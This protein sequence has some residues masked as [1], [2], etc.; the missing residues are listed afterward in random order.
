MFNSTTFNSI[1]FNGAG[2]NNTGF[3]D[4]PA[5]IR[6][7]TNPALATFA[8]VP[9]V[10]SV[11][12]EVVGDQNASIT[13]SDY[14]WLTPTLEAAQ[15]GPGYRPY[16]TCKVV[17]DTIVPNQILATDE[18]RNGQSATAPDG[19]IFTVGADNSNQLCL[20]KAT[21][22]SLGLGTKT[23]IRASYRHDLNASLA[24]SEY[25][26]GTYVIDIY[27]FYNL[28]GDLKAY[29]ARSIDGG[30]TFSSSVTPVDLGILNATTD[31]LYISAGKPILQANNV[32]Y[33]V[34]FYIKKETTG[35]GL[36]YYDVLFQVYKGG[37][38]FQTPQLWGGRTNPQDFIIQGI[39]NAYKD[40][41]YYLIIS[42]Y[43]TI[44]E[45]V[46]NQNYGLYSCYVENIYVSPYTQSS[47][48]Y[49]VFSTGPFWSILTEVLTSTS[50]STSN[51][52]SFT[53]PRIT[54]DGV[55]F[56]ILCKAVIVI[57]ISTATT[58]QSNA[59]TT[60]TYRYL[61]R[62]RDMKNFS[63]PTPL[64]FDDGTIFDDDK[65]YSFVAQGSYAYVLGNGFAWQYLQ[66]EIEADITNSIISYSVSEMAGSAFQLTILLANMNNQWVGPSTTKPG[67]AAIA[68]DM[69]I[70]LEQ[71][72]YNA[73]GVGETVPRN[74]FYIDDIK[75]Q[76]TSNNNVVQIVARDAIKP[77]KV[78]TTKFSYNFRGPATYSDIFGGNSLGNWNQLVGQ[79]SEAGGVLINAS[80]ATEGI[81]SLND[82]LSNRESYIMSVSVKMPELSDINGSGSSVFLLYVD[83]N[84]WLALSFT[85]ESDYHVSWSLAYMLDGAPSPNVIA[86]GTMPGT[87]SAFAGMYVPILIRQYNYMTFDI[88][89]GTPSATGNQLGA[90]DPLLYPP[91][92]PFTFPF[93][94]TPD[95]GGSID[96]NEYF[97]PG[98]TFLNST[99][100]LSNVGMEGKFAYFKYMQFGD[101]QSIQEST[102]KL[103]TLAGLNRFFTKKI[104]KDGNFFPADY[105]G[106]FTNT[107]FGMQ[108][109][110]SGFVLD[111]LH[112]IS[113]GD[114]EMKAYVL[115][116]DANADY[117]FSMVFRAQSL[118][119]TASRYKVVMKKIA[120][121]FGIAEFH[122]FKTGTGT[123]GD[124]LLI[125]SSVADYLFF[126]AGSLYSNPI[127]VDITQPHT[128]KL[129][130][131]DNYFY[132]F[133][134]GTLVL[135]WQDNNTDVTGLDFSSGYFGVETDSNST[136]VVQEISSNVMWNQVDNIA[137]NPGDDIH[138]TLKSVAGA[139]GGWVFSD[140]MGRLTSIK[141]SPADIATYSYEDLLYSQAFDNSDKEYVNQVTVFGNGVSAIYQDLAS[142]AITSKVRDLTISDFKILTYDDALT[143]A[144]FEMVNNNRFISQ[145]VPT[146]P[147]NVGS[148]IFDAINIVNTGDNSTGTD[149]DFRAYN[150]TLTNDGSKG[151]YAMEIQTG[152]L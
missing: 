53:Y 100:A 91:F 26:N 108:V 143:R 144:K 140:I 90:Y 88:L 116:T 102:D 33:G 65:S 10:I 113:D 25:I 129:V 106:S 8:E 19:T 77:L 112:T 117:S 123:S 146:N 42:A 95:G 150:Q 138:N 36:E 83:V 21:D 130:M 122:L 28:T 64:V 84:D 62:S 46:P 139:V 125:K 22:A 45:E 148:E 131:V 110:P 3:A 151:R 44:I 51:L 34:F 111:S 13:V 35:T 141:L 135:A 94:I 27:A 11:G 66:N 55:G 137:V 126:G 29:F 114:I 97:F 86:T 105:Y 99:V 30:A 89:V 124:N 61:L 49:Q 115:P 12:A 48:S 76:V 1:P 92:A 98:Q 38:N 15:L 31:N 16:Y 107:K 104:F 121:K 82:F 78:L 147:L 60:Q 152:S 69:K 74:I 20:W 39:D 133:V 68:K 128:Y 58:G 127:D 43:H 4:V 109:A 59:I 81:I 79:W 93:A 145:Q 96:V 40:G 32:I 56:D 85:K 57:G 7:N 2:A 18:V 63:Y 71:G 6:V 119:T 5:I 14:K 47:P 50:T 72:Y 17:N 134:D 101:S 118:S 54:F 142:I 132:F 75:Q 41:I 67:A 136:L 120:G 37:S 70:Y 103:G 9:A 73:S 24:I 52:N 87:N 80:S 149:G 23:V